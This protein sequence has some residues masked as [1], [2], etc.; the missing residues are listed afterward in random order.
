VRLTPEGETLAMPVIRRH[1]LIEVFLVQVMGF[2]WD[3]VHSLADKFELGINQIL[4]DR[5][6]ELAGRPTRCPHGEPIPS[7][8]GVMPRVEDVRL[9]TLE[10]GN[11]AMISRIKAHEPEKLRYF[12][13]LNMRPGT[14]MTLVDQAPFNGP[15]RIAIEKYEHVIGYDL[16]S[17]VRVSLA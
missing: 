6:F 8:E 2:G 3:E 14:P 4:E 11:E 17:E 5:I 1:R 12:A 10:P 7:K 9:T 16:A 13:R 15:M